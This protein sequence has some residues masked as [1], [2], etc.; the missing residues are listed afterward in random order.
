LLRASS[1]NV[2]DSN[3]D[4][5]PLLIVDTAG[6]GMHEGVNA[7]GSRYNEIEAE[8]VGQHVRKLVSFGV[9]PQQIAVI[10][11]YNGQV[12]LLR[13]NLLA[14]LPR[15][16]IR[17]VDGFQGGEREAVV[18]SL[19]R[20]SGRGGQDGIGFLRDDRRLNVAVTRAK[21]HCCVVADSE[22]VSQSSFIKNLLEWMEEHGETRSA[23]EYIIEDQKFTDAQS[24]S[25]LLAAEDELRK[26]VSVQETRPI[27]DKP[28]P[29][30]KRKTQETDERELVDRV[31][32]FVREAKPDEKLVFHSELSR[33]GRRIVH[34]AAERF[35]IEHCS[36]GTEGIDRRLTLKIP[37]S[38]PKPGE[39]A[40]D[41][42]LPGASNGT[43][44]HD[45]SNNETKTA[46]TITTAGCFAALSEDLV[47]PDSEHSHEE[48]ES[49]DSVPKPIMNDLLGAVARERAEREKERAANASSTQE[50]VG[51]QKKKGKKKGKKLG[52]N[53]KQ[54]PKT[55]KELGVEGDDDLDD[56]AFL[57]SQIEKVQNSHGRTI[58][59]Q[60]KYRTIVNGI[61]ISKPDPPEKRKD[62]SA[63]SALQAKLKQA[64]RGRK[65]HVKKK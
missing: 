20:S 43:I 63:A 61:L 48:K 19:V 15:L 40:G 24:T 37:S 22:T 21:R 31:E 60:G 26:L 59:G 62:A 51:A 38:S 42:D 44:V 49:H 53:S 35:G 11:P 39:E 28:K 10:T 12:E 25:D 29:H 13:S 6:C 7:T 17:S 4:F 32:K 52:G 54:Q 9:P 8:I 58:Q 64:Q 3:G 46:P 41:E 47:E 23:L 33:N 34:E 45:E 1:E 5:E 65:A 18:L 57:D 55:E 2:D 36:E 16:E 27:D 56:M 30:Q 14:D 50:A